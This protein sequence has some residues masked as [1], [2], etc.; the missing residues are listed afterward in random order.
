M[1]GYFLL[2]YFILMCFI[3][4]ADVPHGVGEN[5]GNGGG[6][7]PRPRERAQ[8]CRTG[9]LR[10]EDWTTRERAGIRQ[11]DE[12][13]IRLARLWGRRTALAQSDPRPQTEWN[14]AEIDIDRSLCASHDP[15]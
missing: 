10:L 9:D 13:T 6:G 5:G 12:E 8:E 4:A 3:A 11:H 2:V 7:A 15:E 1:N 14:Q